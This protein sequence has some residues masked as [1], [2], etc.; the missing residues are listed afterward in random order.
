MTKNSKTIYL[1]V[2]IL[3]I[4]FSGCAKKKINNDVKSSDLEI[5]RSAFNEREIKMLSYN[6]LKKVDG[7]SKIIPED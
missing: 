2:F 5:K 7:D 4:F 6:T 1:V 3:F